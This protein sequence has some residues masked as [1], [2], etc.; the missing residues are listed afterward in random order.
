[1]TVSLLRPERYEFL[2]LMSKAGTLNSAPASE[3]DELVVDSWITSCAQLNE[4]P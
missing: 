3:T 1:M 2:H 4:T